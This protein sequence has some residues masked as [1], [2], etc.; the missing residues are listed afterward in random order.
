[1]SERTFAGWKFFLLCSLPASIFLADDPPEAA[2]EFK[3]LVADNVGLL[4][5]KFGSFV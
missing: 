1:M 2:P 3:A 4:V 5:A